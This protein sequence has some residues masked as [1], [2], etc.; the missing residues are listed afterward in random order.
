MRPERVKQEQKRA[1][2][3]CTTFEKIFDEQKSI[4]TIELLHGKGILKGPYD[5]CQYLTDSVG[6][7]K[8]IQ[9]ESTHPHPHPTNFSRTKLVLKASGLE[10]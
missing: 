3:Q 4:M 2:A 10:I 1:D 9:D 8:K 5:I 7:Y 6:S